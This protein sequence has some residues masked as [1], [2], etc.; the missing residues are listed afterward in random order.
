MAQTFVTMC[1]ELSR[2]CCGILAPLIR[3]IS[4]ARSVQRALP[5]GS[6]SMHEPQSQIGIESR[7]A[8]D[9]VARQEALLN[10]PLQALV[11]RLKRK[12]PQLAVARARGRSAH[13]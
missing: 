6:R 5:V 8:P 4:R 12:P 7:E 2:A 1:Q 9:V 10:R 3:S 11:N 13:A